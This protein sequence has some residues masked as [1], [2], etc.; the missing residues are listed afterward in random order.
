MTDFYTQLVEK[1]G[2]DEALVRRALDFTKELDINKFSRLFFGS[3]DFSVENTGV[4]YFEE[5]FY[6]FEFYAEILSYCAEKNLSPK[7]IFLYIY[8]LLLED[9]FKDFSSRTGAPE[10]FFNTAKKI[11]EG[12]SEYYSQHGKCGLYEYRFLANHVRGNIIRLGEFEYQ[13]GHFEGKRCI[14]LHLPEKAD[15]SKDKRLKSYRLA[16]Q[17]F[18]TY[19]I[20]GDSWLLYSEHKK[21]LSKDSRILDFMNDFDIISTHET[22]DYSELFHVFGRLD[23]Y[24]YDNLPKETSLQRAY[25][26]RVKKGLP[27]G[28][29]IGVLKY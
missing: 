21:M 19:D 3:Q 22:C 10:L 8:I 27:I 1:S 13:Y 18:G 26:E 15:L 12:A 20:I 2:F 11:A 9:S 17:Y 6:P 16:R 29:G 25:A 7:E 28:S 24:S 23:D 4:L 5:A 14:V